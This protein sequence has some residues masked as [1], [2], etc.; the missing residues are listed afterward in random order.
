[1]LA[2]VAS[3]KDL[4]ARIS[5]ILKGEQTR[6]STHKPFGA[7]Q[8]LREMAELHG[9]YDPEGILEGQEEITSAISIEEIE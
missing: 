7:E 5:E 3:Q 1:M 4:I 8:L 6:H 9:C 2:I